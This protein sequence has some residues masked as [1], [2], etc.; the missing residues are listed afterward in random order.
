MTSRQIETEVS[1]ASWSQFTT[2]G[3]DNWS[4][5]MKKVNKPRCGGSPLWSKYS[6]GSVRPSLWDWGQSG[7]SLAY[8]V[9]SRSAEAIR[10]PCLK[11]TKR[12]QGLGRGSGSNIIKHLRKLRRSAGFLTELPPHGWASGFS[13]PPQKLLYHGINNSNFCWKQFT[14]WLFSRT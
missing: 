13:F 8:L 3:R 11:E 10:R 7:A 5:L 2:S 1:Q 12:R 4:S 14:F 9:S 6:E